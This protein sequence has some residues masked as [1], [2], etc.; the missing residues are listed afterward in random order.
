M[1]NNCAKAG[2]VGPNGI[3]VPSV[4]QAPAAAKHKAGAADTQD[5]FD[6]EAPLCVGDHSGRIPQQRPLRP[7]ACP[8]IE[9]CQKLVERVLRSVKEA[10]AVTEQQRINRQGSKRPE[11][12]DYLGSVR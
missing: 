1:G 10:I 5:H 11:G 6:F 7:R 2:P 3:G 4:P 9:S 8:S 12:G